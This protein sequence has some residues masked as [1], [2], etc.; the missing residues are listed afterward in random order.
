MTCGLVR[1]KIL[2][3]KINEND[4]CRVHKSVIGENRLFRNVRVVLRLEV[5]A[6]PE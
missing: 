5:Y 3:G 4:Y 1:G 2:S 6:V